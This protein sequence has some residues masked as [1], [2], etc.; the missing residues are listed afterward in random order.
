MF[1]IEKTENG[2]ILNDMEYI[3]ITEEE[4]ISETQ[5]NFD[6]DKGIILLDL[7]CT[8]NGVHFTDINLFVQSLKGE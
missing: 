4:I 1:N 5:C 6:T 2:F 7:S 3:L 8:I